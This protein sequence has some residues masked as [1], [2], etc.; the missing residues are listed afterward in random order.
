MDSRSTYELPVF[1][2]DGA[3]RRLDQDTEL[4]RE[5]LSIFFAELPKLNDGIA[6]A[7]LGADLQGVI[8]NSHSLKG[9]LANVGAVRAS[10]VASK[11]EMAARKGE[12]EPLNSWSESL[13]LELDKFATEVARKGYRECQAGN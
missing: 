7:L 12:V 8:L 4:L 6:S 5:L 9:A 2:L 1:D 10:D 13:R 3:L 11:L